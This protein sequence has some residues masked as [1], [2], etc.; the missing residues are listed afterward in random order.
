MRGRAILGRLEIPRFTSVRV[1]AQLNEPR[2]GRVAPNVSRSVAI[3]VAGVTPT[4]TAA[5]KALGKRVPY[6]RLFCQKCPHRMVSKMSSKPAR[7]LQQLW[8]KTV[9]RG[10]IKTGPAMPIHDLLSSVGRLR[11]AKSGPGKVP[12]L[13]PLIMKISPGRLSLPARSRGMSWLHQ[14]AARA[15]SAQH[16]TPS[17]N[18]G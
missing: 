9:Q 17:I 10:V 16:Q 11:A 14:N 15:S 5:Q 18:P 8:T 13:D 6:C 2:G 1:T 3:A 12:S 4:E 7:L